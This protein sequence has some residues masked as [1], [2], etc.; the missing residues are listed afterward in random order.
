MDWF[1]ITL[2]DV[3][4]EPL[5]THDGVF[6]RWLGAGAQVGAGAQMGAGAQVGAGAQMGAG[7]QGGANGRGGADEQAGADEQGLVGPSV[8]HVR[9]R[10]H[11]EER[12]HWHPVDTLYVITQGELTVGN[13]GTYRVGD[14]RWVRGG[15]FYGPEIAGPDGCEFLLAGVSAEPMG[16]DYEQSTAERI[17]SIRI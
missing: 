1:R 14:I 6:V 11:Y 17:G 9:F 16:M 13:E 3:P 2:R 5:D 8:I 10:P 15:T 12:P 7:T 4:W